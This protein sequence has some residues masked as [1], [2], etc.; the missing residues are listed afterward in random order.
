MDRYVFISTVSVYADNSK[1]GAD[2][3]GPLEKYTGTDPMRET[4]KTL[5][6]SKYALYGPLK[7]L[8]E[9]EAQD[10]FPRAGA[11]RPAGPHRRS[12]RRERPFHLLARQGGSW[13]HDPRPRERR[14]IRCNS[15]TRATSRNG[16]SAW[17]SA[18]RRVSYNATG[19]EKTLTSRCHA[20]RHQGRRCT[21]RRRFEWAERQFSQVR[22]RGARNGPTCRCGCPRPA[23]RRGSPRRSIRRASGQGADLPARWPTRR[24]R[25]WRGSKRNRPSGRPSCAR[26]SRPNAKRKC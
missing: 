12:G 20:R 13:R 9:Q 26:A 17:P 5:A 3:D 14:P 7:A 18:G 10:P 8:S 19:P 16:P 15:S 21:R 22:A 6:D 24:W 25:R 23:R 4:L 1:P 11:H 2:E